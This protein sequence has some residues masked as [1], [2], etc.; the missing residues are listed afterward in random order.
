MRKNLILVALLA[1]ILLP[2]NQAEIT[3]DVEDEVLSFQW[4]IDFGEVYVST[5]PLA[6]TEN[7]Y[8]RTS[9]SSLT[10]GVASVYSVSYDGVENWR[11]QN[12]NS[13]M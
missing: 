4:N 5:K 8:V 11:V 1:I 9:S 13:T 12:S 7:I 6:T 2:V 10:Q 3:S